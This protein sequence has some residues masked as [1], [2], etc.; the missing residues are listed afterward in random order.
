ME[1]DYVNVGRDPILRRFIG[2]MCGT[3]PEA[4]VVNGEVALELQ[5]VID[6][7]FEHVVLH[8]GN[9]TDATRPR[10]LQSRANAS[11]TLGIGI[12][13]AKPPGPCR[14]VLG[15]SSQRPSA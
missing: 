6:D 8:G 4:D 2:G 11:T 15:R 5:V 13:G 7:L 3:G 12:T 14:R 1:S 9:L 10:R